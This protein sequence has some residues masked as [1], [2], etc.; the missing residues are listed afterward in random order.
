VRLYIEATLAVA[1]MATLAVISGFVA[2]AITGDRPLVM[3]TVALVFVLTGV[4]LALRLWRMARE[5]MP[6]LDPDH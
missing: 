3:A 1:I 4:V 6:P 2:A 5:Q